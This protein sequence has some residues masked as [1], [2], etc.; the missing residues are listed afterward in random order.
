MVSVCQSVYQWTH[1]GE[2]IPCVLK[3]GHEAVYHQ[4]HLDGTGVSWTEAVATKDK[5]V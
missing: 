3:A 5:G 2:R 4:Q 1:E